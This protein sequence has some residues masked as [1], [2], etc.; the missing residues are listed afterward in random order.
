MHRH[1]WITWKVTKGSQCLNNPNY[2]KHS[3]KMRGKD[4]LCLWERHTAENTPK[5]HGLTLR[6]AESLIS[7]EDS[8]ALQVQLSI[9]SWMCTK[10]CI[11]PRSHRG[12]ALQGTCSWLLTSGSILNVYSLTWVLSNMAHPNDLLLA[13]TSVNNIVDDHTGMLISRGYKHGSSR[14]EKA[15]GNSDLPTARDGWQP[16]CMG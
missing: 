6:W 5:A 12:I 9:S 7:T 1:V 15:E 13:V 8:Q 3:R 16:P 4:K 2:C 11:L 10:L 14:T